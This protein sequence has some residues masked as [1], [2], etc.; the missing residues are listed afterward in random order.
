MAGDNRERQ[1]PV[2]R[3]G[4][5]P[6]RADLVRAAAGELVKK[7]QDVARWRVE[8]HAAK[9]FADWVKP[10]LEGCD[11]TEVRAAAAHAPEQLCALALAGAQVLA[12]GG[13]QLHREQ[14][15]ASQAVPAGEPAIAAAE[16]ETGDSHLGGDAHCGGEPVGLCVAA[17][18]QARNL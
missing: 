16:G 9:H 17:R 18:R 8:H 3:G 4:E 7:P 15:V 11:H 1:V 2:G 5:Q 13:H 14:V 12:L 10:V 6:H